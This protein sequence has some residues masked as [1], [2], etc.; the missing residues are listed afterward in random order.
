MVRT[1]RINGHKYTEYDRFYT[2]AEAYGKA[3]ELK[4]LKRGQKPKFRYCIE[5]EFVFGE[6]DELFIPANKF[7][8]WTT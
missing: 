7:I 6:I 5:P 1:K 8:L 2:E 3:M 4:M